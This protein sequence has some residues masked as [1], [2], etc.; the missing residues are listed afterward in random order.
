MSG[1][2]LDSVYLVN[3]QYIDWDDF[4]SSFKIYIGKFSGR[5]EFILEYSYTF[6]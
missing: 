3:V 4:D 6:I 2:W 5:L 1:L